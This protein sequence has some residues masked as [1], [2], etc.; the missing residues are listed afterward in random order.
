LNI[1]AAIMATTNDCESKQAQRLARLCKVIEHVAGSVLEESSADE[2]L[3][4]C[5]VLGV[6][7]GAS[8]TR[9][10]IEVG[11][12]LSEQAPGI[13]EVLQALDSLSGR[14]RTEV[15]RSI[16]RKRVPLLAFDVI[17]LGGVAHGSTELESCQ[18]N[19]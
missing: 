9:V 13:L 18:S 2:V 15:A 1:E 12:R 10:V 16:N 8:R 11:F 4:H 17:P 7:P 6:V 19:E 5:E 14:L 3:G